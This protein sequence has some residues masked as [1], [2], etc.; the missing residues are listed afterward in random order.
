MKPPRGVLRST[1]LTPEVWGFSQ[2]QQM[3]QFSGHPD[4][5][6]GEVG[7]V[8]TQSRKTGPTADTNPTPQA[9]TCTSRQMAINLELP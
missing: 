6:S 2:H 4:T 3:L 8:R 7:Q 9:V 5:R 1:F